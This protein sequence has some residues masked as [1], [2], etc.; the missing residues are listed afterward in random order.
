[1]RLLLIWLCTV[2]LLADTARAEEPEIPANRLYLESLFAG[3][4]NPKGLQERVAVSYRRR[5]FNGES[6]LVKDTYLSVGPVVTLTPG[7]VSGGAQVQF[8]PLAVLRL[9]ARY[10]AIGFFGAFG[11]LLAFEDEAVNFGPEVRD[12]LGAG[13]SAGGSIWTFEGLVQM[14]LGGI[15]VRNNFIG[16]R[17]DIGVPAGTTTWFDQRTDL[18]VA[19]HGWSWTNDADLLLQPGGGLTVGGRWS[20]AQAF[21]ELD[22]TPAAKTTHR[23]GPIVAY[24]LYN[25]PGAAFNTPTFFLLSQWHVAHPY[26]SGQEVSS[27][28]P[29]IAF[30]FAFTG[31]LLPW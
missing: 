6:I 15:A 11:Q 10:E 30:G 4:V 3:R 8:M 9:T 26:R 17:S 14:K 18:L 22:R 5:L 25:K 31:D 1:M 19:A 13:T 16:M 27:A 7:F 12:A 2:I 23:V 24:T 29:N 20:S 21:H 28:L